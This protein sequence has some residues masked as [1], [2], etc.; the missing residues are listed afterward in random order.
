MAMQRGK[1]P[2]KVPALSAQVARSKL[3]LDGSF[4]DTVSKHFFE[5][6]RI[7]LSLSLSVSIYLS[8]YLSVYLSIYLSIYIYRHLRVGCRGSPQATRQPNVSHLRF[9]KALAKI[10]SKHRRQVRKAARQF[11]KEAVATENSLDTRVKINGHWLKHANLTPV[12]QF[13]SSVQ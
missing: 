7:R 12:L 2:Q 9:G 3:N 1:R 13:L 5:P 10:R 4:D 8:I 6:C 11:L